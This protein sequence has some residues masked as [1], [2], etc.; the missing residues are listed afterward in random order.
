MDVGVSGARALGPNKKH[1][2]LNLGLERAAREPPSP[3]VEGARDP[4]IQGPKFHRKCP[5][6]AAGWLVATSRQNWGGTV[7]TDVPFPA[8]I[9]C[10]MR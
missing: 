4:G 9:P 2:L 7:S 3:Q 5:G 1:I 10:S 8:M 6:R